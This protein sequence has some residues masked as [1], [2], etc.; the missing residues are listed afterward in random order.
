MDARTQRAVT[1]LDKAIAE[2][3]QEEFDRLREIHGPQRTAEQ[4]VCALDS[5]KKLQNG[6]KPKYDEWDAIF[7]VLWY[8]PSHINLA[9]TLARELL[10]GSG[11][12]YDSLRLDG[13]H[14]LHVEDFGCGAWAMQFGLALALAALGVPSQSPTITVNPKDE[15]SHMKDLG[16]SI[17][18]RFLDKS[19]DELRKIFSNIFE[20]ENNSVEWREDSD[21]VWLAGIHVMYD[22]NYI[23]SRNTIRDVAR[24]QNP[25]HVM[26]TTHTSKRPIIQFHVEGYMDRRPPSGLLIHHTDSPLSTN[27]IRRSILNFLNDNSGEIGA[28]LYIANRISTAKDYLGNSV[29]WASAPV[30]GCARRWLS[31]K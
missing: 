25:D 26:L 21:E 11:G 17:W 4:I 2:V 29:S 24:E 31:R 7:Y 19:H 28:D 1:A 23:E 13:N 9:Y 20:D 3:A 8:Q 30:A 22:D 12:G 27:R 18:E 15:S 14:Y 5:L 16:Y 10:K 6:G